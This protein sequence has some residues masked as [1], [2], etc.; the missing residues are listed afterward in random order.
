MP[1]EPLVIQSA[2]RQWLASDRVVSAHCR[3][4]AT[5]VTCDAGSVQR[6]VDWW[7]HHNR[8]CRLGAVEQ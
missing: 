6:L 2:Q 3:C 8:Q 7:V 1:S 4:G 5:F